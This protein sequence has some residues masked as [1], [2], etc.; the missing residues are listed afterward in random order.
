MQSAIEAMSVDERLD[1]VEYI[2]G[3]VD[4]S[5]IEVTEEQKVMIRARAAELQADASIGLT[6]NELDAQIGPRWA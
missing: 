2:E 4:Q 6:W 5:R 3:T 1:L